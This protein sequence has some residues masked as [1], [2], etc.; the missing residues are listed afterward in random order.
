MRMA[1]LV[2]EPRR[3]DGHG[4]ARG[5][6]ERGRAAR[7]RAV[8]ADLQDLHRSQHAPLREEALDGGLRVPGQQGV[9]RAVPQQDDDRGVVDVALGQWPRRVGGGG[10]QDL[11][12]HPA[13]ADQAASLG[14][15]QP[16]SRLAAHGLDEQP[17]GQCL[18]RPATVHE[19]PDLVAA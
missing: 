4:W 1:V 12:D 7:V 9:E 19:Q 17:V 3:D 6:Q 15:E 11:E 2:V 5:R 14:V 16:C 8:V 10:K 13:D 18:G